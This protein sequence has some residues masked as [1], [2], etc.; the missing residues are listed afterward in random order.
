M[1]SIFKLSIVLMILSGMLFS[2]GN[3]G[4][5]EP[6]EET[7]NYTIQSATRAGADMDVTKTF[8]IE[9]V[10][11]DS[12]VSGSSNVSVSTSD[13]PMP[14]G[15]SPGSGTFD[16]SE[17]Q[18]NGGTFEVFTVSAGTVQLEWVNVEQVNARTAEVNV[19]YVYTL[20]LQQ[21]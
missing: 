6:S 14:E 1:K 17:D 11:N 21:Q 10:S 3:D 20:S 9:L 12:F 18:L 5:D 2:C 7:R 8:T 4:G 19:R 15:F 13:F 16:T